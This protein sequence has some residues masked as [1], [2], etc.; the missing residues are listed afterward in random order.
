MFLHRST[1]AT[2]MGV[3]IVRRNACPIREPPLSK[4]TPR[5]KLLVVHLG[6]L[7]H[8]LAELAHRQRLR[9]PA[10]VVTRNAHQEVEQT[11]RQSQRAL[12]VDRVQALRLRG[13]RTH[14]RSDDAQGTN[15]GLDLAT[16]IIGT[17]RCVVLRIHQG[18]QR[19]ERRRDELAEQGRGLL[20]GPGGGRGEVERR[21][22]A[23]EER[24][25]HSVAEEG[26]ELQDRA[27]NVR[28][29]RGT[30]LGRRTARRPSRQP[31]SSADVSR[32]SREEDPGRWATFMKPKML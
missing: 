31:P 25:R 6:G 16:E 12:G 22:D 30:R 1:L 18:E 4:R 9:I 15:C 17:G 7:L 3:K 11:V 29:A 14:S 20:G 28:Q 13:L 2:T 21:H 10:S 19:A 27:L 5:A 24:R 26:Q 23:G 8:L 32:F